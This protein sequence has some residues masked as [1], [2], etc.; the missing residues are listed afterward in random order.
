MKTQGVW[1]VM[2][3][4]GCVAETTTEGALESELVN[5]NDLDA[6][7]WRIDLQDPTRTWQVSGLLAYRMREVELVCPDGTEMDLRTWVEHQ[8]DA[9][10][11][12]LDVEAGIV[13]GP[14]ELATELATD[15]T[16]DCRQCPDGA[17]VCTLS[18]GCL[19]RGEPPRQTAPRDPSNRGNAGNDQRG[20][21]DEREARPRRQSSTPLPVPPAPPPQV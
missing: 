8:R 4:A 1:V 16:E 15:C 14:T 13:L 17:W 7:E 3:L 5:L 20:F 10:E 18:H 19:V 9:L 2:L 11:L 6:S 21:E 12:P